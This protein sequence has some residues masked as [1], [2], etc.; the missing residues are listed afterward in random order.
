MHTAH[1]LLLSQETVVQTNNGN[2]RI[3]ENDAQT[4]FDIHSMKQRLPTQSM[5]TTAFDSNPYYAQARRENKRLIAF[6]SKSGR[7]ILICPTKPYASVGV[8]ARRASAREWVELWNFVFLIRHKLQLKFG[9]HF[10]ISTI[11]VDVPQLHI[12][13]ERRPH[14]TYRL[15]LKGISPPDKGLIVRY[16][17][18]PG[19]W[20]DRFQCKI[21]EGRDNNCSVR[22][23][24]VTPAFLREKFGHEFGELSVS[25][26]QPIATSKPTIYFNVRNWNAVPRHFK[27]TLTTYRKYLVQ[28]ELGHA[29][30]HIWDHDEEPLNG[31]CPV[32]MQQSKGTATCKP[33]VTHHPHV[34]I[35]HKS[36]TL[37]NWLFQ[38]SL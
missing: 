13:L 3:V 37:G 23:H 27:G 6:Q 16:A 9:G 26:V 34:W 5:R 12:R 18:E 32:M 38:E 4:K 14:V 35:P 36:N 24:F 25:H 19:G 17:N 1:P 22:V 33:G 2:V 28:H 8:F 31:T 10:Y 11:G 15:G 7:S 21:I 20:T 30:F 29:L